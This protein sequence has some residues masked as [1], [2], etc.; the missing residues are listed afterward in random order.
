MLTNISLSV[1]PFVNQI[2]AILDLCT[3]KEINR[4][5]ENIKAKNKQDPVS[6]RG[7]LDTS[8]KGNTQQLSKINAFTGILN[9]FARVTKQQKYA[10]LHKNE[11]AN[12]KPRGLMPS[13]TK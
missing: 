13:Y 11:L 7:V 10:T 8:S 4:Y 2:R 5:R 6:C 12:S 9:F 1:N 3:N